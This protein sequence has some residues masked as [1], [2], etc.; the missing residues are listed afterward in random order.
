MWHLEFMQA[1][2][3]CLTTPCLYS[4]LSYNLIELLRLCLPR[5]WRYRFLRCRAT[6]MKVSLLPLLLMV[7][8]LADEENLMPKAWTEVKASD[9]AQD[10][11]V[12]SLNKNHAFQPNIVGW[13]HHKITAY[14]KNFSQIKFW[15]K[16]QKLCNI[17]GKNMWDLKFPSHCLQ[18]C[19]CSLAS[20]YWRFRGNCCF[21][22]L[23]R[24][25]S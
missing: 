20:V 6:M 25:V 7:K 18:G 19:G 12:G 5:N 14:E 4:P 23:G 13:N 11:N 24:R 10:S 15:L 3:G 21:Q 8:M 17:Y 22:L 1:C 9:S 16:M 2:D